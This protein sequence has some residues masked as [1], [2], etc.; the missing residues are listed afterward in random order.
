VV[1]L[2]RI[3]TR[4]GDDGSTMLGDGSRTQ[5]TDAR[6]RAFGTVDEL[7]SVI[8]LIATVELEEVLKAM[9]SQIQNDLFDL[10][11]D[12][13]TPFSKAEA[14]GQEKRANRLRETGASRLEAMIDELQN[15]LEPL[16]SFVLPGGSAAGAWLHLARTVCRRAELEALG[17]REKS[18]VNP[19]SLVY[20]NR[21]SDLL[22][23]MARW[24]NRGCG[25]VLWSPGANQPAPSKPKA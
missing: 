24:A 6:V 10:G 21:L 23:V 20:L 25:E 9:L 1:T 3:Y 19:A 11:S 5:K 2:N 22:F 15:D 17:L 12:L 8:G 7:N 16:K 4:S 14:D 13:C 18:A